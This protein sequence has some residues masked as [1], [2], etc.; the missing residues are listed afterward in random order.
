MPRAGRAACVH[1]AD[2]A[3]SREYVLYLCLQARNRHVS[4]LQPG[5]ALLT[6]V[7]TF[8]LV[9]RVGLPKVISVS[10]DI[11]KAQACAMVSVATPARARA[12]A[13]QSV[14]E[15]AERHHRS[16]GVAVQPAA[17]PDRCAAAVM[18]N[19]NHGIDELALWPRDVM[20]RRQCL[21]EMPPGAA[22]SCS[23]AAAAM[24]EIRV[25]PGAY[26]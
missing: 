23:V 14:G 15:R 11:V 2:A 13:Q 6:L 7:L 10:G 25:E 17:D 1:G 5:C 16:A 22:S 21:L 24:I 12:W 18:H 26:N 3:V 9:L 4:Q 8:F 19:S 20:R